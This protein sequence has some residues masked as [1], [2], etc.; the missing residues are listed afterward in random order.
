MTLTLN[1][2]FPS[3]EL[4]DWLRRSGE[5]LRQVC[6]F[7]NCRADPTRALLNEPSALMWAAHHLHGVFDM[8]PFPRFLG[9]AIIFTGYRPLSSLRNGRRPVLFEHLSCDRMN[10]RFRHHVA[11]P[12]STV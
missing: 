1:M 12:G 6:I 10:L 5:T 2:A 3:G 9:V 8:A 11:L 4:A 7:R